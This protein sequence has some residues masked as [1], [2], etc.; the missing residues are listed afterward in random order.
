MFEGGTITDFNKV[1]FDTFGDTIIGAMKF[2][3]WFPIANEILWKGIRTAKQLKDYF[4]AGGNYIEINGDNE[5]ECDYTT[6]CTSI[7]QYVNIYCGP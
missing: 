5:K 4:L 1:W 3:I 2:N 7:Q 6:Q